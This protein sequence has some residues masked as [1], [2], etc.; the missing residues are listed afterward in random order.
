MRVLN[1][2]T[3]LLLCERKVYSMDYLFDYQESQNPFEEI[4]TKEH[5][6]DET[7]ITEGKGAINPMFILFKTPYCEDIV[8]KHLMSSYY[9]PS[10]HLVSFYTHDHIK[11]NKYIWYEVEKLPDLFNI[12]D[13]PSVVFIDRG[14]NINDAQV[15]DLLN[16]EEFLPWAWSKLELKILVENHTDKPLTVKFLLN[17]KSN[18][19]RKNYVPINFS[20]EPN[21]SIITAAFYSDRMT[22][23]IDSI[24]HSAFNI[25]NDKNIIIKDD[26]ELYALEF[27]LQLQDIYDET[28][29][30]IRKIEQWSNAKRTL[31]SIKQ[32]R[33][34]NN[35]TDIGYTKFEIPKDIYNHLLE[36]Y[37]LNIKHRSLEKDP[38]DSLINQ[39]SLNTTIVWLDDDICEK[40]ASLLK[41]LLSDWCNCELEMTAFYGVREYY[42]G[43]ILR[44]HVDRINTH[45]VSAILQVSLFFLY[46]EVYKQYNVQNHILH[47]KSLKNNKTT[48]LLMNK[49]SFLFAIYRFIKT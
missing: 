28:D 5:L 8:E 2:V 39:K 12:V 30:K 44:Y 24:F 40:I 49:F 15:W 27:W 4:Y 3:I 13:F 45:V 33:I 19:F 10:P 23:M 25:K 35:F 7:L 22:V 20:L 37:K 32:P 6:Y 38:K 31:L 42:E 29:G 41:P 14:K 17:A 11:Y 34:V 46:T 9:L 1:L 18:E 26:E 36:Y 16:E 43:A 47:Y 48:S 21:K